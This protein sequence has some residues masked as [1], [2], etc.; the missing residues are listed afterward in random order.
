M[1]RVFDLA[2]NRN[3]PVKLIPYIMDMVDSPNKF[4]FFNNARVHNNDPSVAGDS[5][6]ILDY[7][8]EVDLTTPQNVNQKI[9]E[10]LQPFRNLFKP[11]VC[12]KVPDIATAID[13]LYDRTDKYSMRAY[14]T[15][16]L[17]M[18]DK[19]IHWCETL[20]KTTGW[21]DR[22]LAESA[23][24]YAFHGYPVVTCGYHRRP[25]EL[26]LRLAHCTAYRLRPNQIRPRATRFRLKCILVL[27]RVRAGC[28]RTTQSLL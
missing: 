3:L 12:G 17:K 9:M 21:Y 14:M 15:Q 11:R 16:V 25:R 23:W 19:D 10:V 20:D 13:H 6:N 26:G 7:I 28:F 27:P 5:F 2:R 4:L 18:D 1:N 24:F 22:A 8:E